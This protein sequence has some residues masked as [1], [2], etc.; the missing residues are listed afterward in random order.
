MDN[1]VFHKT[2]WIHPFGVILENPP[3]LI[4]IPSIS[5]IIDFL[6]EKSDVPCWIV[7]CPWRIAID[8]RNRKLD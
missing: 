2:A 1:E 8:Q 7:I 4:V 5:P 6:G 3:K